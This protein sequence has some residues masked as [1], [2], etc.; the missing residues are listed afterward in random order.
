VRDDTFGQ[1]VRLDPVFAHERGQLR[2]EAVVTP[3]GA[4]DQAFMRQ[5]VQAF[6]L[7]IALTTGEDERE[8]ARRAGLQKALLE[9]DEELVGCAVPAIAGRRQCVAVTDDRD[10]VFDGN[11]LLEHGPSWRGWPAR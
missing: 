7:G 4:P 8:I 9:R 2:H 11:D 6:F 3:D 10:G 1:V 5:V